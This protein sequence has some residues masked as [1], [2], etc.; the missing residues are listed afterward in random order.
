[1][2][3]TVGIFGTVPF[4]MFVF[5]CYRHCSRQLKSREALVSVQAGYIIFLIFFFMK[6]T[7]SSYAIFVAAFIVLP[8]LAQRIDDYAVEKYEDE[9][10]Y[11][12]ENDK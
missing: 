2:L 9:K 5:E 6:N 7:I 11:F 8:I 4:I 10:G 3:A 12:D 1:M